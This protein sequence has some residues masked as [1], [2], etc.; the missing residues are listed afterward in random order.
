MG[1]RRISVAAVLG[2][3]QAIVLA[4]RLDLVAVCR[5][6][7]GPSV[8]HNNDLIR[9]WVNVEVSNVEFHVDRSQASSINSATFGERFL[10]G[11]GVEV[12][13]GRCGSH[14]MHKSK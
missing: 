8:G 5:P 14:K 1:M 11:I 7:R 2:N 10:V 9:S 12:I 13:G 4:Q 3:D 6:Q